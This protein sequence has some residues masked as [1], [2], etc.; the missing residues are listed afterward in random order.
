[1][2][3]DPLTLGSLIRQRRKELGLTLND[4]STDTISIPTI[5]NIER[6]IT[7]SLTNEKVAYI[8]EQLGLTDKMVEQM[9]QKTEAANDRFECRLSTIRHLAELKLYDD[10]QK[11]VQE[12]ESDPQLVEYPLYATTMHLLKGIVLRKQKQWARATEVFEQVLQQIEESDLDPNA[13]LAAEAYY[14]LSIA[15]FYGEQNFDKAIECADLAIDTYSEGGKHPQLRGRILYHKAVCFFHMEQYGQA[16]RY[17]MAARKANKPTADMRTLLLTYN[18][19]GILH[20]QQQLF[21]QSLKVFR[22]AIELSHMYYNDPWLS[23]VLYH[24]LGKTYKHDKAYGRALQSLD[25]AYKLCRQTD[26]EHQRAL[27][28]FSYAQVYYEKGELE[29]ATAYTDRATELAQKVKL[30]SDYLEILLLKAQIALDNK[31]DDVQTICEEGIQLAEKSKLFKK[32]KQFHLILATY[33]N[34]TSNRDAF[35]Q[36]TK[37]IF[38]VESLIRSS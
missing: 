35:Q 5:S 18:L 17:T 26:D 15:T 23:S 14:N 10:A 22:K 30:T 37:R 20:K 16:Y 38:N 3:L 28:Y 29:Q 13:N 34:R 7:G 21:D 32:Q 27:L 36:E 11:V 25:I 33:Y 8:R 19:E 2:G 6:G 9:M 4:L 1:M 31:S 24:N 12:L